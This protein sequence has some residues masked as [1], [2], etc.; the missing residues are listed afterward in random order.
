MIRSTR[1]YRKAKRIAPVFRHA[2]NAQ[3]YQHLIGRGYAWDKRQQEWVKVQAGDNNP[4]DKQIHIRV[5]TNH[6]QVDAI[7]ETIAGWGENAGY[8]LISKSVVHLCRPPKANDGRVYLTLE[9]RRQTSKKP[10]WSED[11]LFG[12]ET[13]D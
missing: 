8:R 3:L 5:T 11:N 2:T 7:A 1:K 10:K 9:R 13:D 12:D 4:P 6:Q